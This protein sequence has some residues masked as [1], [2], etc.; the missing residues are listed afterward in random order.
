MGLEVVRCI[1]AHI[2]ITIVVILINYT[3]SER[4]Y[5]YPLYYDK[6]LILI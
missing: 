1:Y 2:L 5:C 4:P 6:R 3:Y